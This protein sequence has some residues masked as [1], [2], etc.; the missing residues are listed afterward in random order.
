M[1]ARRTPIMLRLVLAGLAGWFL[2]VPS[3]AQAQAPAAAKIEPSSRP[4]LWRIE[5]DTPCFL[6]GTI[7]LPD[8]R[9]LALH[10]VVDEAW[11]AADAFY[12]ELEL[13]DAAQMKMIPL[14][15]LPPGQTL[16]GILPKDLYAR[17]STVLKKKGLAIEMF[18]NFKP[19]VFAS[20]L[21]VVDYLSVMAFKPPMDKALYLRSAQAGKQVGGLERVEE[22]VAAFESLTET[23][24]HRYLDVVLKSLEEPPAE[25]KGPIESLITTYVAGDSDRLGELLKDPA[26]M[27]EELAE[28]FNRAIL[29]DRNHSMA[30][31]IQAKRKEMPDRVLFF[32]VGAGHFPGEEG[33]VALLEKAGLTV[34]RLSAAD[35]G[36]VAPAAAGSS[37]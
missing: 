12:A 25:G 24:T 30:E 9:V 34:S 10:P 11:E 33:I 6:L 31:R 16:Q 7:H 14:M 23:E 20:N 15:M 18:S 35:A 13:D 3:A 17:A 27:D 5:G 8:D 28:K 37:R 36:K 4:F 2:G 32:A 26:G 22:Q 29:L 21:S 19:W 1:F